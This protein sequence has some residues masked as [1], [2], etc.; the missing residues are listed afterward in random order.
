MGLC[1]PG[2]EAELTAPPFLSI[3]AA[4]LPSFFIHP[5]SDMAS[6]LGP[7]TD[8]VSVLPIYSIFGPSRVLLPAAAACTSTLVLLSLDPEVTTLDPNML[9]RRL[10]KQEYISQTSQSVL[11]S[12]S[13]TPGSIPSI[14]RIPPRVFH[15]EPLLKRLVSGQHHLLSMDLRSK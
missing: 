10:C 13:T 7:G 3:S 11:R 1:W 12:Q 15:C 9:C 6:C 8:S 14:I 2:P 5:A 4:S